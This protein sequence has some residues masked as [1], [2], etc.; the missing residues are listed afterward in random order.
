MG[1]FIWGG[2]N[3][4]IAGIVFWIADVLF[5]VLHFRSTKHYERTLKY[6]GLI[7]TFMGGGFIMMGI[8]QSTQSE[9]N[10]TPVVMIIWLAG[11]GIMHLAAAGI[12]YLIGKKTK[13]EE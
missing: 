13:K 3:M 10:I 11:C 5:Q 12:G 6:L 2:K 9:V 7:C 4:L 1:D 8:L